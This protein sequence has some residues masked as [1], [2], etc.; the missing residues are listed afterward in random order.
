VALDYYKSQ[1]YDLLQPF[2]QGYYSATAESMRLNREFWGNP[3]ELI[4]AYDYDGLFWIVQTI[5]PYFLLLPNPAKK[6][7]KTRLP[8]FEYFFETN[9]ISENYRSCLVVSPA[10]MNWNGSQWVMTQKGALNF[11]Y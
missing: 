11:V 4:E 3:L 8:G 5:E 6:I 1:K 7:A 10:Y 9:F 2:S